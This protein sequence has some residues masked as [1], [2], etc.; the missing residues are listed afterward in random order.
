[1]KFITDLIIGFRYFYFYVFHDGLTANQKLREMR[2]VQ[3]Y[4]AK[5]ITLDEYHDAVKSIYLD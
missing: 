4:Y 1:M 3:K 5:E 2:L